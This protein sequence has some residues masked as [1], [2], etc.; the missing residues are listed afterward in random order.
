MKTTKSLFLA[1]ASL[2]LFACSNED[3]I[4]EQGADNGQT[5]SMF[6]RLEGLSDGSRGIGGSETGQD[7]NTVGLSNITVLFTDGNKVVQVEKLS[8]TDEGSGWAELITTGHIFHGITTKATQVCIVGNAEGKSY[9]ASLA[10]DETVSKVK[11][12]LSKL[13]EEQTFTNVTLFG[14]DTQLAPSADTDPD[15]NKLLEAEVPLNPLISRIEIG[16][17]GC[18]D[19]G[20]GTHKF[21]KMELQSIG[22]MD[23]NNNVALGGGTTGLV[24]MTLGESG[25][26]LE[27][28]STPVE[29][30]WIFGETTDSE[31]GEYTDYKW[32][33]DKFAT[34]AV[35]DQSA[36]RYNPTYGEPAATEG[37]FVYHFNPAKING[38]KLMNVKLV[39][40]AYIK[41]DQQQEVLFPYGSVVTARFQKE[42]EDEPGTWVDLVEFE[43]GKIY[44]LDYVF[45][46]ENVGPWDPSETTCVKINVNVA[47]WDVVA[48]K[49]V[50]N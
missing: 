17:I 3:V 45:K 40:K 1:F 19:L 29:G 6:V 23:Y 30:K 33:W 20:S 13:S 27:P 31:N 50:F 28:G 7:G 5:Q 4:T 15:G 8:S 26:L 43:A 25:N 16:N 22:L 36:D 44:T 21:S 39:T 10:K 42:N 34:G 12:L 47:K 46:E 11:D 24:A 38:N 14:E 41:N 9:A 48:L 49:P 35:L 18:E 2:G 37:K 32:A